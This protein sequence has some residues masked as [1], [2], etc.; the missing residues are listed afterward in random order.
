M[1]DVIGKVLEAGMGG[2]ID[3]LRDPMLLQDE[4][5]KKLSNDQADK[6]E[7]YMALALSEKQKEVVD[8][9]M[10]SIQRTMI[11][12]TDVSYVAGVRDAIAFL[13]QTGLLKN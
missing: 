12:A 3:K 13:L 5:Y 4:D 2:V 6:E 9:Y 10:M 8:D 11:R 7:A 1:E